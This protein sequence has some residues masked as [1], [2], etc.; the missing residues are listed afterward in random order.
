MMQ[1]AAVQPDGIVR[2]DGGE[3]CCYGTRLRFITFRV[4]DEKKRTS[5]AVNRTCKA[6]NATS[7]VLILRLLPK[8]QEIGL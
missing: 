7:D 2:R 4:T 5:A 6:L 1:A 3:R 8:Q